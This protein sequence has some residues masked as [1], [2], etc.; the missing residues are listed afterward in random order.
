M[1][2]RLISIPFSVASMEIK[3]VISN[4]LAA[5]HVRAR[6]RGINRR[7]PFG[8]GMVEPGGPDG[9]MHGERETRSGRA[10]GPSCGASGPNQT[11]QNNSSYSAGGFSGSA[12][13]DSHSASAESQREI[14][15]A[16]S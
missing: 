5:N 15:S 9:V 6:I 8:D 13:D 14:A 2:I 11:S 4:R 3:N 10:Y 16:T 7:P 1:S 12:W